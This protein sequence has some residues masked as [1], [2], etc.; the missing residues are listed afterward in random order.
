MGERS[1]FYYVDEISR[2]MLENAYQAISLTELWNYMKKDV[3]SY[4]FC[5]DY[6]INIISKKMLE[7]GYDGHSG[8]SFGITMRNMQFIALYGLGAHKQRWLNNNF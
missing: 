6:E 1:L 2:V 5:N 4:A 7:L 8:S 3:E